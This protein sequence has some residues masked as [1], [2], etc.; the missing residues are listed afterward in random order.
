MLRA[1]LDKPWRQHSTNHQLYGH[2]PPITKTIK[3]RRIR[4][5]G[6]CWRSRDE[7][8][9]HL[10]LMNPS[11]GRAKPPRTYGQQLCENTECSPE[12]LPKA[13]NDREEWRERL[14]N[15]HAGGTTWYIYI[16]IYIYIYM[17]YQ[18]NV[19]GHPQKIS[20]L[21][22]KVLFLIKQVKHHIFL[23]IMLN[24]CLP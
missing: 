4:H 6:H 24:T 8:I 3:A 18:S 14:R 15:I 12:D 7:L 5:A 13:M 23:F 11:H 19:F 20:F 17:H 21:T 9:S 16:Y 22:L 1:I 2:L 10:L